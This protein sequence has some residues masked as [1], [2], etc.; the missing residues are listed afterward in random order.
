MKNDVITLNPDQRKAIE[1]VHGPVLVIAGAGTGKTRVI[2]EKIKYLFKNNHTSVDRIL[3]LT[4][5]DKAARE[6]E[7]RLDEALPYGFFQTSISTFHSFA[8]KILKSH[9]HHA[10]L[11]TNYHLM[12]TAEAVMFLRSNFFKFELTYF[13]PLGNPNKFIEALLQHFDRLKDENISPKEYEEFVIQ[14]KQKKEV[15][16]EEIEKMEELTRAYRLYQELK[17][18]EALLDFSDLVYQSLRLLTKRKTLVE[19]YRKQFSYMFVDEFQDTNIAQYELIKLLAPP[20]LNPNLMVVGDDSQAIYKFRGASIS[21]IM[22]FMKDYPASAQV[23]LRTNYRSTQSILDSSYRLIKHN[24]PDTLEAKLGISKELVSPEKSKQASVFFS[25]TDKVED[26]AER[27]AKI[28]LKKKKNYSYGE[29]AILVRANSH[30]VPFMR[31]L[32]QNGIPYQFLGPSELFKQ[33]EVKDLIAYLKLLSHIDDSVSF[34]RVLSMSL[35]E[36]DIRD[37]SHLLAFSK[38]I[39]LPL[40][41]AVEIVLSFYDSTLSRNEFAIYKKY[42]PLLKIE[43]YAKL[44]I[45]YT[46]I[47]KHLK[48]MRKETVG[49]ILFSFLEDSNYLKLLATYKTPAEEKRAIAIS[50][51]FNRIKSYEAEHEDSSVFSFVDYLDM[52]MELG[53][54][55]TLAKNDLPQSDSVK[56]LTVHSSKG[57]EFPVVFLVNLSE[58]RFPPYEKKETI[59]IPTDLVKEILPQGD[60]HIEEERRLFYVGMTRAMKELYLS[61]SK[62]YSDSKRERKISPFVVEAIGEKEIGKHVEVKKEE[63]NQLSIFDFQKIAEPAAMNNVLLPHISFSQMSTYTTC[64]LQYK[65]Q[66]ILK[67]PTVPSAALSFGDTIH[68]TLQ[69][70]YEEFRT[71]RNIDKKRLIEIYYAAWAPLGY[72]SSTH[73]KKMKAEGETML[74]KFFE[75]YHS[76]HIKIVDLERLFK[77]RVDKSISVT[78]KIDRVDYAPDNTLEIIDYKTG[79]KPNDTELKKSLQLSIYALAATDKGLYRKDLAE[80]K[81]TFYYLQD[82]EK[83]TLQRTQPEIDE[84]KKKIVETASLIKS[85]RFPPRVGPWCNF[86]SFRMICEAWQ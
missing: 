67:I 74:S 5:T 36:I 81:L 54:S 30:S 83:I 73:E 59:P 45:I 7:V 34:Y 55:P 49:Q 60:Y 82:M 69:T 32:A 8:D 33:P 76:P 2:V 21:N 13:R 50:A 6:M 9:A 23:N 57:L 78:G 37:I 11:S 31:A 20:A 10:G 25:L 56:I 18:K 85:G 40:F 47:H 79:K 26:E 77:I 35:F 12:S 84:M 4:F 75:T 44:L 68:R 39:S 53:E 52:S 19:D 24:D 46:F 27:V 61:S 80:V 63:K 62:H 17:M 28:I 66:Y 70:F 48:Q 16:P 22:N 38:K 58:G 51:F 3:A 64:P 14:Q 65:Y 42:L 41:M 29:F 86:C 71:N 72:K 1:T 15:L 43:T